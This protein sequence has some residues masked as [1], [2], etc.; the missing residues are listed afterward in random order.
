MW[1]LSEIQDNTL[2][3]RFPPKLGQSNTAMRSKSDTTPFHLLSLRHTFI[4]TVSPFSYRWTLTVIHFAYSDYHSLIFNVHPE[5]SISIWPLRKISMKWKH[6]T[7][8]VA[9]ACRKN[10]QNSAKFFTLKP[11]FRQMAHPNYFLCR[12]SIKWLHKNTFYEMKCANR[13]RNRQWNNELSNTASW[14]VSRWSS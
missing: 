1:I 7:E 11:H 5:S 14:M 10:Q 12:I 3:G 13:Q 9:L 8:L 4:L 6:A 2:R